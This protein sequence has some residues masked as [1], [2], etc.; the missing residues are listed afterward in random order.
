MCSACSVTSTIYST[1][2]YSDFPAQLYVRGYMVT[3]I[4]PSALLWPGRMDGT[5]YNDEEEV[6]SEWNGAG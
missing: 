5:G 4:Y 2:I 6:C 3:L 1:Y